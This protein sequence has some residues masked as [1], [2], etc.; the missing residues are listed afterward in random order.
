M[1]AQTIEKMSLMKLT[2]M[3]KSLKASIETDR[4]VTLTADELVAS[5]IDAEWDERYNRKLDR[6]LQRAKFR[7][8]ASVENINFDD[9]RG[10]DKNQI[11]RLAECAFIRKKENVLITGS[12]GIGKSYLASALGYQA[13]SEGYSV[14]YQHSTRMFSKLK[15]AKSDGSYL[16]E[17]ARLEKQNLLLIDD[18][19]LQPLDAASRNI[20]MDIIEDRHGKASTMF[21]SQVPVGMWHEVIGEQTIADAILDRIVHDAHRIEMHGESMRKKNKNQ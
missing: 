16:K 5:L 14:S 6:S 1:N 9:D 11:M 15:I 19:G 21:T 18:F 10:M 2:G 7:Y 4:I 3:V 17:L 20:L 12:T 13:C 8:K